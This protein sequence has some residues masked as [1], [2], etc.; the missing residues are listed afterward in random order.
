MRFVA[1]DV[2][3]TDNAKQLLPDISI[4][5]RII[6]SEPTILEN[7]MWRKQIGLTTSGISSG[8]I[9]STIDNIFYRSCYLIYKS[10][11]NI[12]SSNVSFTVTNIVSGEA[13]PSEEFKNWGLVQIDEGLYLLFI[14]IDIEQRYTFNLN[15]NV[16]NSEDWFIQV[17][18]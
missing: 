9:G 17:V 6:K 2:V 8:S 16:F 4:F 11:S 7:K 15:T 14:W 1:G 10:G 12:Q 3:F 5:D 18:I 13:I